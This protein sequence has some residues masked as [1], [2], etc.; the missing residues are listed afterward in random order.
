MTDPRVAGT[1][2]TPF[3]EHPERT[4]RDLF[5]EAG[6]AALADSG[7]PREDVEAVFY[8]NFMGELAEH[9]GHQGP[10]MAEA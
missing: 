8:G 5:A 10:L 1:G 2:L 6:L 7:V 4:G 3:G 9:Q